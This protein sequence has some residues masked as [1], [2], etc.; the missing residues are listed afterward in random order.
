M[1]KAENSWK[2]EHTFLD[3]ET[4]TGKLT[5]TWHN[6]WKIKLGGKNNYILQQTVQI[7]H[8]SLEIDVI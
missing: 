5:V 7:I 1:N 2:T 4:I 8:H 6:F 3:D